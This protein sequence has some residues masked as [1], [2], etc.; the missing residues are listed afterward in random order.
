MITRYVMKHIDE[1]GKAGRK[2]EKRQPVPKPKTKSKGK[3][4]PARA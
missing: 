3:N 2:R 1:K 4:R